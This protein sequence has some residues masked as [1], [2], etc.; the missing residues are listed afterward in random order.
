MSSI[1]SLP[2]RPLRTEHI[3]DIENAAPYSGFDDSDLVYTMLLWTDESVYGLG[4]STQKGSWVVVHTV[5]REEDKEKDEY[6]VLED[7]M[8]EWILTNYRRPMGE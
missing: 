4:F 3:E 1:D 6:D 2:G 8:L 5:P 7:E